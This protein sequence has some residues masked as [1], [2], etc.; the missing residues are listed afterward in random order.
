MA[1]PDYSSRALYGHGPVA[2]GIEQWFPKPCVVGSNPIGAA[3]QTTSDRGNT[4][5]SRLPGRIEL[6]WTAP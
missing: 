3:V 2:Q 4:P 5:Q 1:L 6:S